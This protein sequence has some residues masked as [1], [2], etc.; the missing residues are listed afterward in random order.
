MWSRRDVHHIKVCGARLHDE[1]ERGAE[2]QQPLGVHQ[3][4]HHLSAVYGDTGGTDRHLAEITVRGDFECTVRYIGWLTLYSALANYRLDELYL[5]L[6]P[7]W[8]AKVAIDGIKNNCEHLTIPKNLISILT[9]VALVSET[10]SLSL[11][12][13]QLIGMGR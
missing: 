1:L 11:S 8:S 5:L 7:E 4:D 10:P 13:S 6:T 2:L 3:N 12:F 9:V